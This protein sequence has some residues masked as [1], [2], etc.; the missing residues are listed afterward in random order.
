VAHGA[1]RLEDGAV[2]D[3]GSDC[4]GWIEVEEEDQDRGHQGAA[5]HSRHSDKYADQKAGDGQA[6]VVQLPAPPRP[7]NIS[8]IL[9][10]ARLE[11]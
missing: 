7:L 6:W 8:Q 3:V 1:E 9:G 5:P 10:F 4:D 11:S 2:Q